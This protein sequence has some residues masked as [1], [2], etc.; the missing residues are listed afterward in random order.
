MSTSAEMA[1]EM[2]RVNHAL[3]ETRILLA[4]LDQVDS[5]RWLSRPANSPLR[6]LVEHAR[7][8]AERVTTYLRDQPRT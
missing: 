4:G 2:E 7:E 8:S 1:R 5:A 3:E 6:T